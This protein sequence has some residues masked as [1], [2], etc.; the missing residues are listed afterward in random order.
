MIVGN[1]LLANGFSEYKDDDKVVIFA[2][3]VSN[4][5]EKCKDSFLREKVLIKKTIKENIQKK[6]IYFSS[7]ALVNDSVK[8][9]PYYEHKSDMELL[10]QS[11]ATE[12]LIIRLPQVF[13]K[14]KEHPTLINYLYTKITKDEVFD[15]WSD[16]NRYIIHMDDVLVLVQS[17]IDNNIKNEIISIANPYRYLI[18]DLIECIEHKVM[19]TAR[20]NVIQKQD[21]YTLDLRFLASYIKQNNLEMN[22]GKDYFCKKIKI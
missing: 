22:F 15:V 17:F 4:S 3:G 16:A 20:Y 12:Y 8:D 9:I 2:S 21:K 13:G 7:C 1:G 10:I 14:I 19:K 18:F 11:M 6:I 5:N